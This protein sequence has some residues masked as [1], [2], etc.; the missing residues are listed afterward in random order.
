[1]AQDTAHTC[2]RRAAEGQERTNTPWVGR[3][4][5][6]QL[7]HWAAAGA[8]PQGRSSEPGQAASGTMANVNRNLKAT[9]D[10]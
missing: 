10:R 9:V 2:T 1:M 7:T 5:A 4:G 3:T 8:V 6:T